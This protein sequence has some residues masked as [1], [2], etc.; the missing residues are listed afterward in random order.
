MRHRD[1][2]DDSRGKMRPRSRS[3][4]P[5]NFN[6][7]RRPYSQYDGRDS[8]T[9]K[10]DFYRNR[11]DNRSCTDS[12]WTER[13]AIAQKGV[14]Q[15]W[16]LSPKQLDAD[17]EEECS[18]SNRGY[19]SDSKRE[20]RK[21]ERKKKKKKKKNIKKRKKHKRTKNDSTSS[22]SD[23]SCDL[24]N[25]DVLD[26][27]W[28][29]REDSKNVPVGPQPV[30]ISEVQQPGLKEY[31]HAL[32][33]GEGE[34]MAEFVKMGKRIPRRG[35]IG[36]TSGEIETFE[37]SGYVMSG[38][39]HRRMEAVRLRKENQVYSADEKRALAMFNREERSK[40]ENKVLAD[41]RE[42]VHKKVK[43]Q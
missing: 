8:T 30:V 1:P 28:V 26:D 31:G 9:K 21:N 39:R 25:D 43:K 38:S 20:K 13:D 15:I 41:F 14:L 24:G 7:N 36:L 4:S 10:T 11:N 12:W 16:G 29:E 27:E 3:L 18:Q 32:L 2:R 6:E 35:E 5:H 42:L 23:A 33:P 22:D 37:T 40:R 34:A 19:N 17:S